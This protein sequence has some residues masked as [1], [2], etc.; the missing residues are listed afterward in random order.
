MLTGFKQFQTLYYSSPRGLT[1][2][3]LMPWRQQEVSLTLSFLFPS[4]STERLCLYLPT[5]AYRFFYFSSLS[6][7]LPPEAS[8]PMQGW[9]HSSQSIWL[10]QAGSSPSLLLGTFRGILYHTGDLEPKDIDVPCCFHLQI[11]WAWPLMILSY[12]PLP[13]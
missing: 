10:S 3:K 9:S 8:F 5:L 12:Y 1:A 6:P 7:F 2:H 13:L 11:S 4:P